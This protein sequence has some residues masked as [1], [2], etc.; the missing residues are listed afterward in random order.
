MMTGDPNK[1]RRP[2][3]P[4]PIE[5]PPLYPSPPARVP[6]LSPCRPPAASSLYGAMSSRRPTFLAILCLAILYTVWGSTYLAQRVAIE[7]FPPL[8]MAGL[9]FTA[10]GVVLYAVLRLRGT[11]APTPREWR[12]VVLSATPLLVTGMG[13][14]AVGIQ[15]VPSGLA[16]LVFGSVPLWTSLFD[17]LCGGALRR[18]EVLGLAVGLAGVAVVSLRGGLS[19]DP[20]GALVLLGAAASYALGCVATRRLPL[21]KGMMATAAQMAYGG[22]A[23][24]IVSLASGDRLSVPSTRAALALGYLVVLGSLVAYVAFGWLLRNVRPALATS[25]AFVNPIVALALGAALAGE[26]VGPA[27]LLG[28]G[29]VLSAVALIA[30]G[31]ARVPASHAPAPRARPTISPMNEGGSLAPLKCPAPVSAG[32]RGPARVSAP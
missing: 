21:P 13:T 16:A 26:R 23:L 3:L 6:A 4:V 25:Y 5:S 10:A 15:R 14:A 9:R 24:V 19:A 22:A 17:W 32:R 12:A 11:P 2:R 18:I 29:L 27:D 30:A 31:R 28:L 8:Q 7:G 1:P 20:I